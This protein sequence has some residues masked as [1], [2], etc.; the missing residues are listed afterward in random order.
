[1]E[2]NGSIVLPIALGATEDFQTFLVNFLIV[3][4][5]L[6]YEAILTWGEHQTAVVALTQCPLKFVCLWVH[7]CHH[8]D[9]RLC[10]TS[11]AAF[12]IVA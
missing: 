9:E 3:D 10:H 6:P 4:P 2:T 8:P 7:G 11:S 1:M 12:A 5:I